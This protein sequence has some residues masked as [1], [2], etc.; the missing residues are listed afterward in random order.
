MLCDPFMK[1]LEKAY[2]QRQMSEQRYLLLEMRERGLTAN[3]RE[4]NLGGEEKVLE[5]DCGDSCILLQ[6][7]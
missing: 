4:Q 1:V 2:S 6:I 3:R 7:Y 5:V